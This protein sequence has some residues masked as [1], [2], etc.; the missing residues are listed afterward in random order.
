MQRRNHELVTPGR[1]ADG[2]RYNAEQWIAQR[3]DIHLRAVGDGG[4]SGAART[5]VRF[6]R[7]AIRGD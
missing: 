7:Y 3:E 6:G 2:Q 4:V 1:H 5:A